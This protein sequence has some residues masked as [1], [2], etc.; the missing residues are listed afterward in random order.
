MIFPD[1]PKVRRGIDR[2]L[3]PNDPVL[4]DSDRNRKIGT[5]T[6]MTRII[7]RSIHVMSPTERK[8]VRDALDEK[9]DRREFT[10]DDVL[11]LRSLGS[12][13]EKL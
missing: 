9:M 13:L 6:D 5:L 10:V 11:F 8:S 1:T 12:N 7:I 4:L 2:Q 3:D